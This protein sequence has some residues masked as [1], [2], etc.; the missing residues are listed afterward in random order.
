M[1]DDG[2]QEVYGEGFWY[3]NIH[4]TEP[5]IIFLY[6]TRNSIVVLRT[7]SLGIYKTKYLI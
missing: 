6:E 7:S 1:V 4:K 3:L 2:V 5:N